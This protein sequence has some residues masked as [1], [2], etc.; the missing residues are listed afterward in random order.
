[1]NQEQQRLFDFLNHGHQ[2]RQNAII[3]DDIREALGLEWGRTE[4]ATRELI[5]DMVIDLRLPIGSSTNGFFIIVNIEDLNVAVAHLNSR[6]E[7]TNL[8]I[9]SLETLRPLLQ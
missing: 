2:G 8:R 3:S 5:R 6:V 9:A 1:M 7:K 4:E